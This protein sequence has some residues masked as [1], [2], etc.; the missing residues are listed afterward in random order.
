MMLQQAIYTHSH[1]TQR[2][3][4]NQLAKINTISQLILV[5]FRFILLDGLYTLSY[6]TIHAHF[7]TMNYTECVDE[8]CVHRWLTLAD[9]RLPISL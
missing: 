5:D 6:N 7:L 9:S 1:M 3:Q 2:T 4:P 8:A